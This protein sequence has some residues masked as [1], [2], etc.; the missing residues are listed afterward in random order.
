MRIID[1]IEL[2]EI[3]YRLCMIFSVANFLFRKAHDDPDIELSI[4]NKFWITK[5]LTRNP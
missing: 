5:F 1:R 4:N 2:N 3:Y